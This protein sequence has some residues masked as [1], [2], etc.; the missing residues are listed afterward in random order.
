MSAQEMKLNERNYVRY[1]GKFLARAA[2]EHGVRLQ[3]PDVENMKQ[4]I[5]EVIT[6]RSKLN[7][8][9]KA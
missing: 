7:E 4:R 6:Q 9:A 5:T 2:A 3:D 1:V 8:Q